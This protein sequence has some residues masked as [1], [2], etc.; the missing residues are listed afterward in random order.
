VTASTLP[1]DKPTGQSTGPS[2]GPS[3]DHS[4]GAFTGAHDALAWIFLGAGIL[5]LV[6]RFVLAWHV[7]GSNDITTWLSFGSAIN[8]TSLGHVYDTVPGFNHPPLMGYMAALAEAL[9]RR[10]HVGFERLFKTPIILA[11]W[12]GAL[13][14]YRSWRIR[15]TRTAALAFL[16]FCWNPT[17]FLVS[18]YHGNTD[19]LCV[20]WALLAASLLDGPDGGRPFWAGAS[21]AASINVKLIPVLLIPV[22]LSRVANRRGAL[23]FVAG[24]SLGV[25]P[26]LPFLVKHWQGFKAHVLNYVAMPGFWGFPELF[27]GMRSTPFL[28]AVGTTLFVGYVR[29]GRFLVLAMPIVLAVGAVWARRRWSAQSMVALVFC[30]FLVVTPG[31][32]VQYAV[33]P[34]LPLFAV[35]LRYAF[36]YALLAGIYVLMTYL[37]LRREGELVF[38]DFNQAYPVISQYLASVAWVGVV[39]IAV[40]LTWPRLRLPGWCRWQE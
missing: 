31:F 21:L 33:Y 19:V 26:F 38:S 37:G 9:G 6:L 32:G 11:E 27:G 18:A 20:T 13:L 17:S 15:G 10:L 2:T 3:T 8:S 4:A 25:V 22:L 14:I 34:V 24:L 35:H 23:H 39:T 7:L 1:Q 40:K 30:W 12:A 29:W 28:S 16:L 36:S 5:G